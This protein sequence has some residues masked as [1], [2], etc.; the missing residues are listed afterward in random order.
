MVHEGARMDLI[1]VYALLRRCW[2]CWGR[3]PGEPF[4]AEDRRLLL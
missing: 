1:S 3:K 4:S 2:R